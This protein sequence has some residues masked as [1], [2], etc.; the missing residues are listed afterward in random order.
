[1]RFCFALFLPLLVACGGSTGGRVSEGERV[2]A[3]PLPSEQ[4]EADG[5]MGFVTLLSVDGGSVVALPSFFETAP[6]TRTAPPSAAACS[7][8]RSAGERPREV[9]AG[10]LAFTIPTRE[11]DQDFEALFDPEAGEYEPAFFE[12]DVE[13]GGI[14]HFSAKGETAPA[15]AAD[16]KAAANV[17]FE[18]PE[19]VELDANAPKDIPLRWTVEGDNDE[20]FVDLGIGRTSITCWFDSRAGEG[21][22]PA[23]LVTEL[24]AEGGACEKPSCLMFLASKRTKNVTVD[25]W[26]MVLAHGFATIKEVRVTR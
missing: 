24:L 2:P 9:S 8:T 20:V 3:T 10:A 13:P 19:I 11:G 16:L 25:T 22:I 5:P 21:T 26:T 18:V 12:A 7:V 17:A 23:S 14:L 6:R 1:M 15:F 4:A